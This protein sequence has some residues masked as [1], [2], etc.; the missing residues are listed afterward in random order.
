MTFFSEG[1]RSQDVLAGFLAVLQEATS[2]VQEIVDR[3]GAAIPGYGEVAV[4]LY[5]FVYE[6]SI[7]SRSDLLAGAKI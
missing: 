1:R 3:M 6:F 4:L 5:E 2:L 7:K